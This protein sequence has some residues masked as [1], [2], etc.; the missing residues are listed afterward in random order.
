MVLAVK[1]IILGMVA[2]AVIGIVAL[3]VAPSEKAPNTE[4]Y[5]ARLADPKLYQDGIFTD[6]FHV[7]GGSY[8][9]RFVP[10]GDSPQL[11]S[12][13]LNGPSFSFSEDYELE[14]TAHDTGISEYYTWKY[15]GDN[16]IEVAEEQELQITINP[17]GNTMGP[18]SVY[19]VE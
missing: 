4:I 5:H 13:T 3:I 18:V 7:K 6:S 2:V 15:L 1:K 9:F 10:N 12:I 19:L 17:H 16:T 11:L 14:G 8:E